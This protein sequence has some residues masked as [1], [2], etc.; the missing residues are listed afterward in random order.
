MS[1][2]PYEFIDSMGAG[3]NLGNMYE[4]YSFGMGT[5]F[6]RYWQYGS[7]KM[8]VINGEDILMKEK[9]ASLIKSAKA[10]DI[11]LSFTLPS[12]N[13]FSIVLT[14]SV[15]KQGNQNISFDIKNVK[16]DGKQILPKKDTL[17]L[18]PLDEGKTTLLVDA[19]EYFG[20]DTK[21]KTCEMTIAIKI[22]LVKQHPTDEE[23]VLSQV[24][25]YYAYSPIDSW[26]NRQ[27]KEAHI[28]AIWEAGFRSIR[29]PITW[30]GRCDQLEDGH[31][32]VDQEFFDH[33]AK[34]IAMLHTDEHPFYVMINIHHDDQDSGG[35][36]RAN[37]Y[38]DDMTLQNRYRD[39][40]TQI[41]E[42]MK[43]YDYWLQ[44]GTNNETLNSRHIWEG[45]EVKPVDIFGLMMFQQ[46]AHDI[47]RSSGGKNKERIIMY[48]T[49]AAKRGAMA[50]SYQN[51]N[52][53]NDKGIWHLPL[54]ENGEIDPFGI[55]EIHPYT[56][57]AATVISDNQYVCKY[58]YPVIYGEFGV[59]AS[60]LNTQSVCQ[61]QALMVSYATLHHIGTYIWDDFGGMKL[62]NKDNCSLTNSK[63]FDKLWSGFTYNFIPSLTA[64]ANLKKVDIALSN[65]RTYMCIGDSTDI[66]LD[67]VHPLT[68][69]QEE[70]DSVVLS[71]NNLVTGALG[72]SKIVGMS[73]TGEYNY[74][75]IEVVNYQNAIS[76]IYDD[77]F[78]NYSY[79]VWD[80]WKVTENVINAS[81]FL[82][83]KKGDVIKFHSPN[84]TNPL[85]VREYSA[86][87]SLITW[88]EAA[89]SLKDGESHTLPANCCYVGASFN[90]VKKNGE[91]VVPKGT[92]IEVISRDYSKP[93]KGFE[94]ETR[95][96]KLANSDNYYSSIY[97]TIALTGGIKYKINLGV[98]CDIHIME[99]GK[100]GVTLKED[101]WNK[102]GDEFTAN[103][104]T[105]YIRMS[106]S[107]DSKHED[108]IKAF[109]EGILNPTFEYEDF[110][111]SPISEYQ[112]EHDINNSS[113]VTPIPDMKDSYEFLGTPTIDWKTGETLPEIFELMANYVSDS[114]GIHRIDYADV[115]SAKAIVI[116]Q[117]FET[118]SSS[119][120]FVI[121]Y[122]RLD[123]FI[124]SNNNRCYVGIN[125]RSN[126]DKFATAV[127]L[128]YQQKKSG[129]LGL[130]RDTSFKLYQDENLIGNANN[131]TNGTNLVVTGGYI[132]TRIRMWV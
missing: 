131:C 41:C 50:S 75:D 97:R 93:E 28:L 102:D 128:G 73:Y 51:P 71:G 1:M 113:P 85:K 43:D 84:S 23:D 127:I 72:K 114:T 7:W 125:Y 103:P 64:S 12:S 129:S 115:F 105:Y 77:G 57:N 98:D 36:L 76:T 120:S 29:L 123:D 37:S 20:T 124:P 70:G 49:Y 4:C 109:N 83:I 26:G 38:I 55:C 30:M 32:K 34:I 81:V 40:V 80:S 126:Q 62:L 69:I 59:N 104:F 9:S 99:Y 27:L 121:D 130:V 79:S 92:Y 16:I 22:D 31:I 24:R 48:P 68:L 101:H 96:V 15:Y 35:W 117:E 33:L 110:I 106:I 18:K 67:T 54:E 89:Y 132:I 5:E 45:G 78:E 10:L 107:M 94:I 100:D 44:F 42:F 21:E 53:T 119:P 87:K 82:T 88:G 46:D 17:I 56:S 95:E 47:I 112:E 74:L 58:K 116:N 11:S 86:S 52:D 14:S 90:K 6:Y 122:E 108:I 118:T 8:S 91:Y 3:Y 111:E 2:S 61:S 13:Q 66:F 19:N 60:Q 25:R 39:L 65:R 63:N